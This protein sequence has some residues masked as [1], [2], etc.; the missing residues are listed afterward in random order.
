[1]GLGLP[2]GLA[3]TI[4]GLIACLLAAYILKDF[5]DAY[6]RD[7]LIL[8]SFFACAA[9][10]L[11]PFPAL[12]LGLF[13][14]SL[15]FIRPTDGRYIAPLYFG[16]L[17][18]F[19]GYLSFDIPFPGLNYLITYYW[20]LPLTLFF[21]M[22][23]PRGASLRWNAVD[24][25]F[26]LFL[27]FTIALDFRDVPLTTGV[28][29]G[30]MTAV[31]LYLPYWAL[32][33]AFQSIDD[34]DL[35]MRG[36]FVIA[37]VFACFAA[38]SQLR[39]WDFMAGPGWF[40]DYRTAGLLRI[41]VTL[42]NGLFGLLCGTAL[43]LML[44]RRRQWQLSTIQ[45]GVI[46]LLLI[47][48][49]L[50]SGARSAF[51]GTALAGLVVLVYRWI[52]F[53]RFVLV[54]GVAVVAYGAI[55]DYILGFDT[56]GLDDVGT[57]GYR[58][59]M[60]QASLLKIA[61]SPFFGDV[62]FI[63]SAHFWHLVQ[64]QGIVDIVNVYLQ[65]ALEY[66]LITVAFFVLAYIFALAKAVRYSEKANS[67]LQ[68]STASHYDVR[69]LFAFTVAY[70][71]LISTTSDTSH[72]AIYGSILLALLRTSA[73]LSLDNVSNSGSPRPNARSRPAF[74]RR[75][76]AASRPRGFAQ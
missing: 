36:Y 69:L 15:W 57:F 47:F 35:F 7:R 41:G 76:D 68:D 32:R 55:L 67:I 72:V 37:V 33:R 71:F 62:Y 11:V 75:P 31:Y 6:I 5:V 66:G 46:A 1:M 19:P 21:L 2:T 48:A 29:R 59:Q 56:S 54:L 73:T 18:I 8:F 24:T 3:A 4:H 39:Q 42:A 25:C 45:F 23:A 13:T 60:I 52:T 28:R 49:I 14:C 63:Q 27:V 64:G 50:S 65:I 10:W 12:V 61:E 53:G 70:M 20:W 16:F 40:G 58:Q 30:L 26:T 9:V 17:L 38:V 44:T 51:F 34:L 43:I 22:R 74:R